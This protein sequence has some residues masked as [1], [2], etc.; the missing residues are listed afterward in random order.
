M[1]LL[2]D[3][4]YMGNSHVSKEGQRCWE[5]CCLSSLG[6]FLAGPIVPSPNRYRTKGNGIVYQ[7]RVSKS[8]FQ[9]ILVLEGINKYSVKN[10][11]SIQISEKCWVYTE[12]KWFIVT[13]Q[14]GDL[15]SSPL[16]CFWNRVPFSYLKELCSKKYSLGNTFPKINAFFIFENGGELYVDGRNHC[17]LPFIFKF[18]SLNPGIYCYQL[19]HGNR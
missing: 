7:G 17:S 11:F 14:E 19:S 2:P 1:T 5:V 10:G 9:R 4:R 12:L 15:V 6:F 16:F 18:I 13:L 8:E 3:I